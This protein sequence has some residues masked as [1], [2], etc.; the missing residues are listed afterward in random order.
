MLSG[1]WHASDPCMLARM[2]ESEEEHCFWSWPYLFH[3][4]DSWMLPT[5][6]LAEKLHIYIFSRALSVDM[7]YLKEKREVSM[8]AEGWEEARR[9]RWSQG[10]KRGRRRAVGENTFIPK[11]IYSASHFQYSCYYWGRGRN[12][13]LEEKT[14]YLS[15]SAKPS[16]DRLC[17]RTIFLSQW[18]VTVYVDDHRVEWLSRGNGQRIPHPYLCP[19][20]L[21]YLL[22]LSD[23]KGKVRAPLTDWCS[24]HRRQLCSGN[25]W[26][27]QPL[28]WRFSGYYH[29]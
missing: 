11:T 20:P 9:E 7:Y 18:S 26:A 2:C 23:N 8:L 6:M 12:T 5:G 4:L 28:L 14:L 24:F 29:Y 15:P 21:P 25:G 19:C 27:P 3:D 17:P 1:W 13:M 22:A 10:T 16:A